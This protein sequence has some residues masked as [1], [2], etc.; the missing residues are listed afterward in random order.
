MTLENKVNVS[1]ETGK[2]LSPVKDFLDK[3]IE[4]YLDSESTQKKMLDYLKTNPEKSIDDFVD[5]D[6]DLHKK[7]K[8][9][10][11]ESLGLIDEVTLRDAL[12]ADV[13]VSLSVEN[14]WNIISD[15]K[16]KYPLS[17][18]TFAKIYLVEALDQIMRDKHPVSDEDYKN[19]L[20]S[21]VCKTLF[22]STN[23]DDATKMSI[24]R[25]IDIDN[26]DFT[27]SVGQDNKLTITLA[28]HKSDEID[29]S[30]VTGWKD[31]INKTES[32]IG[33]D[34]IKM[35]ENFGKPGFGEKK[36]FGIDAN[37]LNLWNTKLNVSTTDVAKDTKT[38]DKAP[39]KTETVD[40]KTPEVKKQVELTPAAQKLKDTYGANSSYTN[41]V[42]NTWAESMATTK[43]SKSNTNPEFAVG[44]VSYVRRLKDHPVLKNHREQLQTLSDVKPNTTD[45]YKKGDAI[46]TG[47]FD[48]EWL[49]QGKGRYIWA[50]WFYVWR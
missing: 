24:I 17:A 46:L 38:E 26:K 4:T 20:D 31:N 39:E 22:M 3:S 28:D 13:N 34:N 37:K 14:F 29:Y 40:A 8:E 2:T 21:M 41:D 11:P 42:Y 49:L 18:D 30:L 10:L 5:Q 36:D 15:I 44:N 45:T 43:I 6:Q 16:T 50:E 47:S 35:A 33:I 23:C 25:D 48:K 1:V 7:I 27:V 19:I 12:K 32:A 9:W